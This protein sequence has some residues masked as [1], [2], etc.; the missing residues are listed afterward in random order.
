MSSGNV[1]ENCENVLND[2]EGNPEAWVPCCSDLCENFGI[3]ECLYHFLRLRE[4]VVVEREVRY[5]RVRGLFLVSLSVEKVLV[6]GFFK[7][8]WISRKKRYR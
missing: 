4:R 8:F 5:A 7:T 3:V 2:G 1:V 6:Y